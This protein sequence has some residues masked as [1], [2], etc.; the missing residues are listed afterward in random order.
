MKNIYAPVLIPTQNR[1]NHFKQCLES[2][3]LCTGADKTD[4]YVALDYPP[5]DKYVEGW[6]QIS[7]YLAV[8]ERNNAFLK[9]HVIRRQYNYGVFTDKSN[10]KTLLNEVKKT[11]D[12][13]IFSEDDNVFCP[14]F[15]EYINKG[16]EK[17][18][19]N[20]KVL[21]ITGYTQPYPFK[22]DDNTY[23]FHSTDFS[24]WGY[25]MW[26][27]KLDKITDEI[28]RGFFKETLS[29]RNV[30]KFYH[31]GLNRLQQYVL[32]SFSDYHHFPLI[33]CVLTCYMIV[34]DMYVTVPVKSKVRNIGWDE[35][36]LSFAAKGV[37]DKYRDIAKRH[38]EQPIDTELHFEFTG[39]PHN[40]FDY[41][42]KLTAELSEAK[43]GWYQCL[44]VV[45][46]R[47]TK[48]YLWEKGIERLFLK[49][50]ILKAK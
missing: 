6:K 5:N 27:D 45:G 29:F 49:L 36:G 33:D 7:E 11:H 22:S 4:V 43:I 9:L 12:R 26:Y 2:L 46:R 48:Y 28:R 34:N 50:H 1:Y 17:Y 16:L 13:F 3:E 19:N 31:H 20:S 23:F 21:A 41:N 44:S 14:N 18:K 25:G 39:D 40:Y 30:Y 24:A 32:Y 42:N 8:K 10:S 37:P 47:I 15:L 35:M 38:K